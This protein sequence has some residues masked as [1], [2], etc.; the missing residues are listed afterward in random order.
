MTLRTARNQAPAPAQ[1]DP[2]RA[3]DVYTALLHS[4]ETVVRGKR[5][6]LR[7]VLAALASGGHVLLEDVPG[8]G[9]TT[10]AKALARSLALN[11]QR[12]QFTPDLLPADILGVSTYEPGEQGGRGAARGAGDGFRFHPGPVFTDI[13]LADEINRASPRTQSALLEAMG[14]SQVSL[15]GEQRRL[16]QTFFVLATQNPMDFEGTYPLPE[17]QMDRFAIRLGLGY[18]SA[19]EEVAILSERS[20]CDPLDALEAVA[21]AADVLALRAAVSTVRV[22]DELKHYVVALVCATRQRDDVRVGASTRASLAL[23]RL[24]QALALFDGESFVTPEH[25][26]EVATDVIA[27]RVMLESEA[28]YAGVTDVQVIQSILHQVEAPA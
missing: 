13:L 12:I 28:R 16:S 8:T 1:P 22:S 17:S 11:F 7:K 26:Q 9:K 24:A 10:L 19:D 23:L 25:A 4:V 14:E 6:V 27:H 3:V 20:E 2:M 15:D 18:V 5:P 21:G